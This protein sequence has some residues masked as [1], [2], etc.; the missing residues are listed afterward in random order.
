VK[1][2]LL[3]ARSLSPILALCLLAAL[4]P[5]SGCVPDAGYSKAAIE[6]EQ[7]ART[8]TRAYQVLLTNANSNEEN[9]FIDSQVFDTKPIDP[10]SIHA[11][12]L[13]TPAEIKLRVSAIKA[14]TD[15]TNALATLAAGKPAAQIQADANTASSSVQ[16]LASD[17]TTALANPTAG[18]STPSYSGPISSAVAAIGAVLTLIEKHRGETEVKES[19][20]KTDPQL[21]ALFELISKESNELYARQKSTLG[22][23]G[24]IL[25]HDYDV[26]RQAKPVNSAE[27]MQLSDRI[28]LYQR[29]TALIGDSD[30]AKAI[31]GFQKSH[32]AL[33][34]A[35]LAPKEKKK[36]SLA[37]LI[38]A[39]K[40]FAT[41][42]TPLAQD[43][44]A[45]GTSF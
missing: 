23:T 13:L 14:L 34:A 39:V 1:K 4:A 24:V 17:A 29:D 3:P 37:Q 28:K 32:D 19:L 43:L 15:Y 36:E 10:A 5:L 8:L 33:V 21:Q 11:Q 38:A 9:H 16:T 25:F 30:P 42:V 20:S 26:A 31:A 2:A 6:F 40:A 35:I 27:L 22:A 12:D 45:F 41:E 18:S 7:S 44:Y